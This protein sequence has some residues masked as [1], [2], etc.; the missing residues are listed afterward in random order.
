[1][2]IY[3]FGFSI[4]AANTLTNI[5]SEIK[6]KNN[7]TYL[8]TTTT[9]EP[10]NNTRLSAKARQMSKKEVPFF[11]FSSHNVMIVQMLNIQPNI[12]IILLKI[13]LR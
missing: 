2:S 11:F 7:I 6:L 5:K 13:P 1:M 10:D 4:I 9:I 8:G 3:Q 12:I